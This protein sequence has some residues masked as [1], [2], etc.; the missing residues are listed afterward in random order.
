MAF[1]AKKEKTIQERFSNVIFTEMAFAKMMLEAHKRGYIKMTLK[2]QDNMRGFIGV[3]TVRPSHDL[4]HSSDNSHGKLRKLISC[5]DH[6]SPLQ[7]Q[8]DSSTR[9][10]MVVKQFSVA[11][12]LTEAQGRIFGD[13]T[14][15]MYAYMLTLTRPN[16]HKGK[17]DADYTKHRGRVSKFMK[18]LR[19]GSANKNG[20]QLVGGQYLGGF[21]SHE[22]T[23]NDAVFEAQGATKLYH[24]HTHIIILSDEK[25]DVERTADVLF[26][27]W[28]ALN[29]D[30]HL[31]RKAFDFQPAFDGSTTNMTKNNEV[32]AIKEAVKY[33]VKP[34]TWYR[35]SD[36]TD[37]Y[38][39]EVFA[40]LYG[41]LKAKKLKQS[42][43]LLDM[44]SNFLKTFEAFEN[45]IGFN[46]MTEFPDIVTQLSTLVFDAN[47][48]KHGGY[49][50]VFKRELSAD[51]IILYNRGLIE[52]VL[53]GSGLESVI[54]GFFDAYMGN[55]TTRKQKLY[56]DVFSSMTFARSIDELV[57][58]L[59][60][61]ASVER[62]KG[63]GL[64]AYDIS[65]LSDAIIAKHNLGRLEISTMD[66]DAF[67]RRERNKYYDIFDKHVAPLRRGPNT[68]IENHR[69]FGTF[70]D[71]QG[72]QPNNRGSNIFV[73]PHIEARFISENS[74]YKKNVS[75]VFGYLG[76]AFFG[77]G[78]N[79]LKTTSGKSVA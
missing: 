40:E 46:L 60:V 3:M 63:N 52:S 38:S 77:D 65:L 20:I 14:G 18:S 16:T 19:D 64:K 76:R 68:T 30:L 36:T 24:P 31:T 1:K 49:N 69:V 62:V 55:M 9:V 54:E 26:D 43:G 74:T 35:L 28:V 56:A 11:Q 66:H 27:K 44:A 6:Q 75:N 29:K 47:Q 45:A 8:Q 41:S 39:V 73:D 71:K 50:A 10:N 42:Y 32:A 61:F 23:L 21:A 22:V 79:T 57:G 48:S 78:W 51:E 25:L 70:L 58:K 5:G 67:L 15:E 59:N 12:A 2:Q 13:V 72:L 34:D 37:A 33:T 4:L 17:L 53:V 7:Q